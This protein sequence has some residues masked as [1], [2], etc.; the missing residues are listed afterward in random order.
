MGIRERLRSYV[1][2][3]DSVATAAVRCGLTLG[4]ATELLGVGAGECVPDD[5]GLWVREELLRVKGE[6][7]SK[8]ES[9]AS[10]RE[11]AQ[12]LRGAAVLVQMEALGGENRKLAFDAANAIIDRSDGK[13]GGDVAPAAS[14]NIFN[15]TTP[16]E[17]EELARKISFI[18]ALSRAGTSVIDV[19]A[20]E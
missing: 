1:D 5:V 9:G 6:V 11:L 10:A 18:T 7:L 4:K 8:M 2:N 13:A 3:G 15:V 20:D 14:I 17:K 12:T 19:S 16:A